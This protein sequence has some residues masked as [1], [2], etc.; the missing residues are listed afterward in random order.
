MRSNYYS[1]HWLDLCLSDQNGRLLSIV[2]RK[3]YTK[4]PIMYDET[5]IYYA[6]DSSY[7]T[8]VLSSII[9]DYFVRYSASVVDKFGTN[10][11]PYTDKKSVLYFLFYYAIIYFYVYFNKNNHQLTPWLMYGKNGY[12]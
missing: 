6:F 11:A 7:F 4:A 5:W 2:L 3:S 8:T 10:L 9:I 12:S 1:G